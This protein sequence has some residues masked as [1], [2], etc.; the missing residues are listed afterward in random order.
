[1]KNRKLFITLILA[2]IIS[3]IVPTIYSYADNT[4]EKDVK[5]YSEA[6]ILVD[7]KTGKILYDKNSSERKYPAST[8]KILTA[9]LTIEHCNLDDTVVVDYESIS[10]VPSG[11]TVNALQVGEDLTV[12]QPIRVLLA[13]LENGDTT[14]I[15]Y[16]VGG[17]IER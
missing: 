7:N 3:I 5:V 16:H 2:I 13:H 15:A 10:L 4:D 11:Y 17:R 8:T 12:K 14:V 9:I 1:M 6:A